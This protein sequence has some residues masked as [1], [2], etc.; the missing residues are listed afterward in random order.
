MMPDIDTEQAVMSVAAKMTTMR[1]RRVFTPSERASSSP[2]DSTF[3][4]H[5]SNISSANPSKMGP[6]TSRKSFMLM[7]A[8]VPMSQNV[9]EG[10]LSSAS[11]TSFTMDDPL[12]NRLDTRM[13]PSTSPSIGS[14]FTMRVSSTAS[15]TA[16]MAKANAIS[17]TVRLSKFSSRPRHAPRLAPALAP[18]R[19]GETS[20]FL[21]M[22]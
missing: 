7:F 6:M 17:C 9:M 4:C 1:V 22:P 5:R 21:N 18:R 10:S 3:R 15:P 8:N 12:E 13:P 2:N 19:S 11:A 14:V 16:A 20:G